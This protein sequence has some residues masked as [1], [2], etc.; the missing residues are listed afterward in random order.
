MKGRTHPGSDF[1]WALGEM[2]EGKSVRRASWDTGVAASVLKD[3]AIDQK[4]TMVWVHNGAPEL[5]EW[6]TSSSILATDWEIFE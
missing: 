6:L 1:I 4:P 2:F 3:S 5:A